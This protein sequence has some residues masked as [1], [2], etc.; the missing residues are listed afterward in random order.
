MFREVGLASR[1]SGL[2]QPDRVSG[3][4]APVVEPDKIRWKNHALQIEGEWL[5]GLNGIPA[6]ILHEQPA[7]RISWSCLRPAA[8]TLVSSGVGRCDGL[9]YA[10]RL[11]LDLPPGKLPIA[12][13]R[14]GRFISTEQSLVWIRWL[15]PVERN[16][17][18]HDGRQVDAAMPDLQ[19]LTWPGH[20][21]QLDHGIV[22][23][24]GRLAETAFP[25]AGPLCRLLPASVRNL[26][27]VKWC[28]R[29]VLTG[30]DGRQHHGW[31]IHE[32]VTFPRAREPQFPPRA[33]QRLR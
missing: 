4:P 8:L 29:G 25:G 16:W 31:S 12:E 21:L 11:V 18:Y 9:G 1:R 27:E 26:Q 22:L 24:G 19:R 3:G 15:G 33:Q 20:Q 17:C 14:W 10:E 5:A 7:G 13:L 2:L 32:V 6:V 28:S 30:A 23:R